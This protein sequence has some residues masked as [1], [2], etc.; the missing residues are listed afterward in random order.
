M[1][2]WKELGYETEKIEGSILLTSLGMGKNK[3][4]SVSNRKETMNM[5][6]LI[7]QVWLAVLS[8]R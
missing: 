5:Q 3:H 1:D 4:L 6:T 8:E 7:R 2:C